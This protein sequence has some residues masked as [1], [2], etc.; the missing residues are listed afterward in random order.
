MESY[1]LELVTQS[2]KAFC[3]SFQGGNGFWAPKSQVEIDSVEPY[4]YDSLE[5]GEDLDVYLPD[6]LAEEKGLL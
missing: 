2:R 4:E 5:R 3:F 6:W 1:T